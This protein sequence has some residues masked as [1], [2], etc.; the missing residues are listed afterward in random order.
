MAVQVDCAIAFRYN[1]VRNI[2]EQNNRIAVRKIGFPKLVGITNRAVFICDFGFVYFSAEITAAET[3]ICFAVVAFDNFKFGKVRVGRPFFAVRHQRTRL[4]R[5]RA[6]VIPKSI[7]CFKH[8][9]DSHSTAAVKADIFEFTAGELHI[10]QALCI[11][12]G[13]A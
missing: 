9:G 7:A 6:L 13:K 8:I 5:E 4:A 11:G 1:S 12:K 2:A 10:F 3:V